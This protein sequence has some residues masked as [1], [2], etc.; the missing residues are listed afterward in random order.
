MACIALRALADVRLGT[1]TPTAAIRHLERLA[2]MQ[3]YDEKVHRELM[4]LE[5]GL[6]RRSDAIRRYNSLRSRMRRTFGHDLDFTPADLA[7]SRR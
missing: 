3:P 6:G 1:N 2:K 7:A 5:I 4:E